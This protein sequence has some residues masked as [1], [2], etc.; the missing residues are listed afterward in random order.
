MSF[1]PPFAETISG[2]ILQAFEN[3]HGS[4][5][6]PTP[7]ALAPAD[8]FHA[9]GLAATEELA[10]ALSLKAHERVLDIG[11]GVGGPARWMADQHAVLVDGIDLS[12]SFITIGHA[13]TKA[14]RLESRVTLKIGNATTLPYEAAVFDKAYSQN[15]AMNIA[16]K[17]AFFQ[18][19]YRVLKPGAIFACSI[20]TRLDDQEPAYPTPW[21]QDG[22]GSFLET[23]DS[24]VQSASQVGF[25]L[26]NQKSSNPQAAA[27]MAK[28]I[29]ERGLPKFSLRLLLG[30][31]F[32]QAL[33]NSLYALSDSV[34][35]NT[36]FVF[37]K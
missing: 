19:A 16:D 24:I 22:S 4:T 13:L 33:L 35:D 8:H 10:K 6:V 1:A 15:V 5:T 3:V 12:T 14:C 17:T 28:A 36:L 23:S 29:E 26:R 7:K 30:D 31:G 21:S 9:G 34:L 11:C 32:D 2:Q 18:E 37:E 25:R 20:F 27:K